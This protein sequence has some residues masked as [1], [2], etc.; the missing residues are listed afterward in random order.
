MVYAQRFQKK[1]VKAPK[2]FLSV[3]FVCHAVFQVI[4]E[5]ET[6]DISIILEFYSLDH[7]KVIFSDPTINLTFVC[8]IV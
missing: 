7:T 4:R 5:I 8:S 6:A 2:Y 1:A 3:I